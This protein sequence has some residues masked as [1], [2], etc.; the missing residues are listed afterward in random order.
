MQHK[1]MAISLFSALWA[2]VRMQ[3]TKHNKKITNHMETFCVRMLKWN[4]MYVSGA[5]VRVYVLVISGPS[6]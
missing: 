2:S 6:S 1:H 5:T 4:V 3:I